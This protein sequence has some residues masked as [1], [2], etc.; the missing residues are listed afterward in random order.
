MQ[1]VVVNLKLLESEN[2]TWV[3]RSL[4]SV[5]VEFFFTS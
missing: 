4:S 1:Q 3:Q 2:L 5:S